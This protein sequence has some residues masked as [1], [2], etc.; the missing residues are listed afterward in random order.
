MP[1][2]DEVLHFIHEYHNL[3]IYSFENITHQFT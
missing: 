2:P 3:K 1:F